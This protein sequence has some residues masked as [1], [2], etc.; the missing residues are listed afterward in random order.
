MKL[1]CPFS[2]AGGVAGASY[3]EALMM[4]D[5]LKQDFGIAPLWL[6]DRSENTEQNALYSAAILKEAGIKQIILVT[7][8]AHMRRALAYFQASGLHVVPAPTA[9]LAAKMDTGEF[10]FLA[11]F[12][13]CCVWWLVC[14]A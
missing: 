10:S 12:G 11:A 13:E 8:A 4:S 2:P 9:F 7:H 1:A 5:S 3:P 6:E 14:G